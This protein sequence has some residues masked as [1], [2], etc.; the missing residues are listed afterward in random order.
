MVRCAA[1]QHENAP[2]AKFC[3][4]CGARLERA[5]PRCG[6]KNPPGNKFCA[7]CGERLASLEAG[8]AAIRDAAPASY[9]PRHLT[10]KILTTR[11]ALEGERKTVTVLFCDLQGSTALAERLGP[12]RM[13]DLLNRFFELAQFTALSGEVSAG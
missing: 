9:T 5:C 2:D 3:G 12:E 6:Q 13:H 8:G 11:S 4:E 10:E 1:C 7:E